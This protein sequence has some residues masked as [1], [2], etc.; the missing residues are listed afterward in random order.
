[1]DLTDRFLA[2]QALL[3]DY[4]EVWRPRPFC[5]DTPAWTPRFPA[6]QTA[7]LR[8]D[9]AELVRLQAD[10]AA[11]LAWVSAQ[12]P[13]L[14][15]LARLTVVEPCERHALPPCDAHFDWAI[16]GRKRE[17]IEAF[18][19]AVGPMEVPV[20][21][22]CAGK[23]HLG[24]RLG[25]GGV[26]VTSLEIDPA[27]SA[28]CARLALR[29]RRVQ[30]SVCADALSDAGQARVAG[31]HVVALHACGEL[32]RSLV[33]RAAQ[34]GAEGF[35]I[36]PCCY[37]RGVGERYR[38]LSVTAALDLDAGD[39]RLALTDTVTATGRERRAQGQARAYKLG[40]I[41][42]RQALEGS[43]YRPFRPV[44]AAWS[45]LAFDEFCRLLA[46]REALALPDSLRWAD[47]LA[48]G[49]ARQ[50]QVAR[51]ELVRHVFRRAL[52]LWLVGDLALGLTAAGYRV[53]LGQFCDR[54]LTPRNL[55][56]Q[57]ARA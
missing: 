25:A 15:V 41:A 5:V 40:F 54:A 21:E 9:E 46:A 36:A 6:L 4:A 12:L 17:Q 22:W 30:H 20:L 28:E 37:D 49:W 7:V 56:V 1:M 45:R 14:A 8:L 31:H 55:L 42:L 2:L 18:A 27:L 24:R 29:A 57:A 35:S 47:W 53:R 38:P 52:E 26:A 48:I 16:P 13:A 10:E 23:G 32:H 50:A 44:P 51:Y 19:A 43:P 34:G 33:R 3:E 39:L 11:A